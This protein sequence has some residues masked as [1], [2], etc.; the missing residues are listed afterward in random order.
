LFALNNLHLELGVEV[1]KESE[2][3]NLIQIII[4]LLEYSNNKVSLSYLYVYYILFIYYLYFIRFDLK[5]QRVF[6][7]FVF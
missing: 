2:A 5:L 4:D 3:E 1:V 7:I 6:S